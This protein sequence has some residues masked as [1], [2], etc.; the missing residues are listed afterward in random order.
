MI[1]S[2]LK[3]FS[4]A[5]VVLLLMLMGQVSFGQK[6]QTAKQQPT[7][8]AVKKIKVTGVVTDHSTNKPLAGITVGFGDI[9][10]D[11]TDEKGFFSI[12]VPSL[13]VEIYL[14]G[15]GFEPRQFSLKGK[16]DLQISMIYET[17]KSFQQNAILPQGAIPLRNNTAAIGL[18]NVNGNWNRPFE[19]IDELLQGQVA[20]LQSIRRSG[21]TSKGANLMLRGQNSL[22]GTN[23]PLLVVDGMLFDPADYGNSL[24]GGN[25]TNPLSLIN[26]QDIDNVSVIKDA[27]SEYGSKGANG[28]IIITTARAKRQAT[29]I[30]FG[31][32]GSYNQMPD[33]L[34]LMDASS[35]RTYLSEILQSKGL[36]IPAIGAMPFMRSDSLTNSEY[37]KYHNNTNWQDKVLRNSINKNYFLKVTGGDNIATYALSIGFTNMEGVLKSNNLTRYNTRFNAAFNF[38]KRLTGQ[39]NLAF[40]YNEQDLR[41]QGID[42][43]TSPLFVSLTKS[44][45]LLANEVNAKGVLSPN[46][47]DTDIFG[48]SNPSALIERAQGTS[49]NY[50]FA[51]SYTFTYDLAKSLKAST[52]IGIFYD[53]N[54]ENIFIPRKGVADDT[55][56]NAI[57]D[58]RLGTQVRRLFST[59]FDAKLEHS[60]TIN[61]NHQ[62]NSRV[63]LRYQKNAA[64]QD[65]TLGYNSA[66][67]ELISVQNGVNA[68]RRTGGG[69]NEWN[70]MNSYFSTQY[71]YKERFFLTFNAAMDGSSRFG[72]AAKSGLGI[73]GVRYS[74][75]PSL[76]AAWIVSSGSSYGTSTKVDLFKFR[77][78]LSRAGND[79]I[80]NYTARQTYTSQN[81]L[82]MQGLVRSGIPNPSIQWETST[83]ANLGV[84]VAFWN[85]RV[86]M[87][88]DLY[89]AKTTDML[90]YEKVLS[91]S[92]FENVLTNG[93]AMKNS[94]FEAMVNV[95]A[96]NKSALKWDLGFNYATNRNKILKVPNEQFL[97]NTLGATI[98]TQTGATANVF[99]GYKTVGVFKTTTDAVA[100]GLRTKNANGSLS[101]FQGGDIQFVDLNGDRIID[102]KDMQ[103]LGS[104]APRFHGSFSSKLSWAKFTLDALFTFSQGNE[105]FNQLRYYLESASSTDNQLNSVVNRWRTEGQ[106]TNMPKASFGDPRGNN[107]FSDRWIEDGSYLRLRNI[108]LSYDLSFKEKFVKNATVYLTGNNLLTFTKYMGFDPEFSAGNAGFAQ[109]IDTGL[110]PLFRSVTMGVRIGL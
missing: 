103:Q 87:S 5:S 79:D 85:D 63:G 70:W 57:A 77:A 49:K 2:N 45:L 48:V 39:A 34:P 68:L 72:S 40:T 108:T 89:S 6:K 37:F 14:T 26:S 74:F 73:N 17:G 75:M 27:S 67:D 56:S 60:K 66:T 80:G 109:G 25:Y 84:D 36:G 91:G 46:L 23:M 35:Y 38:S 13:D 83:K 33:Q 31:I 94:G 19:S 81:F 59:Y 28:A 10:A 99:Y 110:D 15:E 41:T 105:V 51:G 98:I 71:G 92:G 65:F 50:R 62:I 29:S 3:Y 16:S 64:E 86:A 9:A 102:E 32:Y 107:R 7:V 18:L 82:G 106:V 52:M 1:H 104:S 93:G 101:N 12:N 20:G 54:R 69:I 4:K 11:L 97:T 88:V 76:G 47:E 30:D 24:M 78:T 55:L 100:S 43:K 58:S 22:H 21:A 8:A 42:A 90:V 61:D 96:I 44:P 95:R 53:K